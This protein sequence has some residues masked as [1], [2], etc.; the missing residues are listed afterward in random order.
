MA[1]YTVECF[2]FNGNIRTI[3]RERIASKAGVCTKTKIFNH[4]EL[5][6]IACDFAK[7]IKC[8]YCFNLQFMK[9]QNDEFVITDVN[10]RLAGGM[11]LSATA[12][13][14][15]ISALAKIMLDKK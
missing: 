14:D 10:L 12:G 9:N 5:E 6:K 15:E 13:W 7:K 4:I 8:P 1:E 3:T 11:S 2:N